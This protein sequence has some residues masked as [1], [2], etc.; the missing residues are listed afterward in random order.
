MSK[1]KSQM[2]RFIG[3]HH[4]GLM[5]EVL[6]SNPY[7]VLP[8]ETPIVAQLVSENMMEFVP[9]PEYQAYRRTTIRGN[10]EHFDVMIPPHMTGDE[11][12]RRLILGYK[13]SGTGKER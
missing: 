3:G 12:V 8:V 9:Q 7:V 2:L 5:M 1:M 6:D 11:M 4:D 10:S 13:E